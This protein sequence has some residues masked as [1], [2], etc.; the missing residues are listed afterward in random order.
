MTKV[1]PNVLVNN[2]NYNN[3]IVSLRV[4]VVVWLLSMHSLDKHLIKLAVNQSVIALH[5]HPTR[6]LCTNLLMPSV[7]SAKNIYKFVLLLA[8]VSQESGSKPL[9]RVISSITLRRQPSNALLVISECLQISK[10]NIC[11]EIHIIIKNN[12]VFHSIFHTYSVYY[13]IYIC[14][15]H[16]FISFFLF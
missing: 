11:F 13:Y 1:L 5:T 10:R 9:R 7:I 2:N 6:V 15:V 12:L 8:Q 3:K 16:F 14:F 4:F